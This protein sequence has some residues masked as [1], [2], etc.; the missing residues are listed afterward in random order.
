MLYAAALVVVI[1]LILAALWLS[2][3]LTTK[4]S[5]PQPGRIAP[6]V[7]IIAVGLLAFAVGLLAGINVSRDADTSKISPP[8]GMA[9][10]NDRELSAMSSRMNREGVLGTMVKP[11]VKATPGDTTQPNS[12]GDLG[13]MTQRL[14]KKMQSDPANGEGWLLLARSYLE[15]RQHEKANECFAKAA[16]LLPPEATMLADWADSY[17]VAHDRKWDAT[18]RG[19]VKRALAADKANPKALSLAGSEA[20]DRADYKSAIEYWKRMKEA[21]PVDSIFSKL[22]DTN[23]EEA[24]NLLKAKAR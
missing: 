21:A 12:G 14:E 23:I 5:D 4:V 24:R 15:L 13:A 7:S 2:G 10:N 11:P 22:A 8:V 16:A 9:S 17:V 3:L 20:Y 19:I 1:A 18:A 6:S